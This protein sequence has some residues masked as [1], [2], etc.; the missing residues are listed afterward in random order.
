MARLAAA[1]FLLSHYGLHGLACHRLRCLPNGAK[2]AVFALQTA[3]L[4]A[5]FDRGRSLSVEIVF[6]GNRARLA[7]WARTHLDVRR[8]DIITT[9]VGTPDAFSSSEPGSAVLPA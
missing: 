5:R 9:G 2:V 4:S 6:P 7:A 3:N 1:S 8:P